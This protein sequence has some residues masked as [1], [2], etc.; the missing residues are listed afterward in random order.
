M[1]SAGVGG[2]N[3]SA[4]EAAATLQPIR[5]LEVDQSLAGE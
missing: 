2:A 1:V 3:C 5:L 4:P